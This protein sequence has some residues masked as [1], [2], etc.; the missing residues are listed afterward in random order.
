MHETS[1]F[2]APRWLALA[3][4]GFLMLAACAPDQATQLAGP[5]ATAPP[6]GRAFNE[7]DIA[8]IDGMIGHHAQ[9]IEM[10][11]LAADRAAHPQL[12]QFADK[13]IADQSTEIETMKRLLGEAG[14]K[15]PSEGMEGMGH[16]GMTMP[17]M[18]DHR[19]MSELQS[20]QGGQF[21]LRFLEMMTVHHQGAIEASQQVLEKGENPQVANLARQ[22][23]KAQQAEIEQMDTWR[24][25]WSVA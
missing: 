9:A 4:G 18:M 8:F 11:K 24:Q 20:L 3:L 16:G 5:T 12:K 15:P 1:C 6:A 19:Q 17:G 7:A 23:I 10:A 14:A 13:I 22:I 21:D 25:R 2:T